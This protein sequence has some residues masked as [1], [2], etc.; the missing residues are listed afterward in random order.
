MNQAKFYKTLVV[1]LIIL[2]VSTLFFMWFNR[3]PRRERPNPQHLSEMLN[4]EGDT[5]EIVNKLS[6]EHHKN[7]K[8]LIHKDKV[9]HDQ[10]Y[11]LIGDDADGSEIL[12]EIHLNKTIIESMTFN[13][14]D[15]IGKHC[16]EEQLKKLK[17]FVKTALNNL[18]RLPRKG[19][20]G[21]QQ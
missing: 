18:S 17:N 16:N 2:N 6:L 10:L 9:L 19:P 21:E 15:D 8:V 1:I 5:K 4:L 3:P 12:E 20:P 13:Y 14:F 7:K 11:L